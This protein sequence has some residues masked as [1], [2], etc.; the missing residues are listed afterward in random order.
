MFKIKVD[1]N[2]NQDDVY[3]CVDD[4]NQDDVYTCV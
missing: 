4:D 1:P 2:D 3:T